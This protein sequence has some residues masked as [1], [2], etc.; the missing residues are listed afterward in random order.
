MVG[1]NVLS[2]LRTVLAENETALLTRTQPHSFELTGTC[3]D[4][5]E[6]KVGLSTSNYSR[7]SNWR[8]RFANFQALT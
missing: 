1:R 4:L 6:V 8:A 5:S 2:R 7:M 3:A